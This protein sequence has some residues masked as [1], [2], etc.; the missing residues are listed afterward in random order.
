MAIARHGESQEV[1]KVNL[2]GL[3]GRL[4]Q[5]A[6]AKIYLAVTLPAIAAI[7]ILNRTSYSSDPG[8]LRQVFIV[9]G[10]FV[11]IAAFALQPILMVQRLHDIDAS[12]W[13]LFLNAAPIVYFILILVLLLKPGTAGPNRFGNDPRV[14]GSDHKNS[15]KA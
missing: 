12:G 6:F 15:S 7:A 9:V 14:R 10:P 3:K 5:P 1:A 8:L 2:F 11:V 4:A 13:W